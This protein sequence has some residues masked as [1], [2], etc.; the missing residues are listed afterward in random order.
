MKKIW[1]RLC[2]LCLALVM[3]V[4]AVGA[5]SFDLSGDGKTNVWD[6]Q[7]L[8]NKG[9]KDKMNEAVKEALGGKGDELHKNADGV[10]EIWSMV[11]LYN[12][13]QHATEGA[14]FKLMT[15][16]DLGGADWA[17][18]PKFVG[19]LDGNGKTI[20]GF[21]ITKSVAA[22]N[23]G[24]SMGFFALVDHNGKDADGNKLQSQITN[25][26]FKNVTV[27][28][29]DDARYVGII[30]GSNRG[31]IRDCSVEAVINDSRTVLPGT[32]YLG[33]IAGRNNNS[34]PAGQV[35]GSNDLLVSDG[36]AYAHTQKVNSKLAYNLAD[37]SYPEGT[38]DGKKYS[39]KI[40]VVGHSEAVNIDTNLLLQDITNSSSFD[41]PILQER[42]EISTQNMYEICTVEWSPSKTLTYTTY[43]TDKDR[44]RKTYS[45]S[46]LYRGIPYNHGSSSLWR[47][48]A[49]VNN[50]ELPSHAFYVTDKTAAQSFSDII[51]QGKYRV[52]GDVW[53]ATTGIT[54]SYKTYSA[55][56]G[57]N[58]IPSDWDPTITSSTAGVYITG[59]GR[60]IGNDC[61]SAAAYGWR[62]ISATYSQSKGFASPNNTNNMIPCP[63]YMTERGIVPVGGI[64]FENPAD[65]SSTTSN[66][67]VNAAYDADSTKF[68]HALTKTK[69]GDFLM[70]YV[71]AGGHT[72]VVMG[73]AV[74][75][76]NYHGAIQKELSYIITCEQ[77][78]GGSSGKNAQG[79]AWESSCRANWQYTFAE[80]LCDGEQSATNVGRYFP[81][82]CAV[83]REVDVEAATPWI[84]MENQGTK[85]AS[86]FHIISTT[87]NGQTVY[88]RTTIS[89][90]RNAV[91]TLAVK[92]YHPDIESGDKFTVMLANGQSYEMTYGQ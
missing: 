59:F 28:T 1:T 4:L 51:N 85:V 60:Y 33:A 92:E 10:Y 68:L 70:N 66:K 61:S 72:R 91:Q 76:R 9:E 74:T 67:L 54:T 73:D 23:D 5:L 79:V 75:I 38:E 57:N 88:T 26:H 39:R 3:L 64:V 86:N 31:E 17:P 25:L 2:A 52:S 77:G 55:L 58:Q 8:V 84:R 35:R 24:N 81:I 44:G 6:L 19:N 78:G 87:F 47:F 32:T 71:A 36:S 7:I 42:R 63:K 65:T 46:T 48:N 45:T 50:P 16:V 40:G 89:G 29:T 53:T 27:T 20:S 80:L 49:W 30:A 62:A 37:L 22:T 13:A 82:T 83:L 14:N 43:K 15:D 21:K 90:S 11:G 12:M 69:K 18:I 41:D 34:D 56:T